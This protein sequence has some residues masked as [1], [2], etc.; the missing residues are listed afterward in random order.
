M[1]FVPVG[2]WIKVITERALGTHMDA[3]VAVPGD[4]FEA[5]GGDVATHPIIDTTELLDRGISLLG[6]SQMDR[7]DDRKAGDDGEA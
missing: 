4:A 2:Y 3:E 7:I 5:K 1:A 6:Y